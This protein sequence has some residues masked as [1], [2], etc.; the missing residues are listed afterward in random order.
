MKI[1]SAKFLQNM[2][3]KLLFIERQKYAQKFWSWDLVYKKPFGY[4][5][6]LKVKLKGYRVKQLKLY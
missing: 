5:V 3:N 2:I 4:R 1:L 6:K